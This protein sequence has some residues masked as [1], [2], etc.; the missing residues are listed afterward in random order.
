MAELLARQSH[1]LQGLLPDSA[2]V[3]EGNKGE[4]MDQPTIVESHVEGVPFIES[5]E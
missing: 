1:R 3:V 2:P 4:T 5:R